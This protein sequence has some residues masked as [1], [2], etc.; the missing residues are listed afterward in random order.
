MRS[1]RQISSAYSEQHQRRAD[2]AVLL[3]DGGE[4]EVG[5]ALG[6]EVAGDLVG[7]DAAAGLLP[8]PIAIFDSC[9]W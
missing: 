9:C 5:V 1:A 3:A 8:E 4:D 7:V 2:E 6:H